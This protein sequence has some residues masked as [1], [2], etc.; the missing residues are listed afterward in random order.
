MFGRQRVEEG[1]VGVVLC[2]HVLQLA[3]LPAQSDDAIIDLLDVGRLLD[4]G[5]G[6]EMGSAEADEKERKKERMGRKLQTNWRR[7]RV[8][9]SRERETLYRN[10]LCVLLFPVKP[11]IFMI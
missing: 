11:E 3:D 9:R 5:L 6:L 1:L 2:E 10:R 4:T 8:A 7:I